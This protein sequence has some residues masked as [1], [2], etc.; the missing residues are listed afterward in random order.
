VHRATLKTGEQV[1]VKIQY[2]GIARTIDADMRNLAAVLFPARLGKDWKF[3]KANFEDIQRHLTAEVDYQREAEN[4]RRA[5]VLF[6]REDGIVVPQVY[7]LFSTNRVLT[8]E[9]LPGLHLDAFLNMK[10]SQAVRDDFGAKMFTAFYRLYYAFMNHADPHSGNYLFMHD[11]RL[12]LL[13]FGCV[14]HYN[15]E[16]RELVKWGEQLVAGNFSKMKE[17]L[18][19]VGVPERHFANPEFIKRQ[20]VF[21][22]WMIEPV[23]CHGPFDFGDGSRLQRG[24]EMFAEIVLKRENQAHPMYA[25]FFRSVF[26]HDALLYRLGAQ[27]DVRGIHDREVQA[28][29]R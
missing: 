23:S 28:L 19:Q 10:P 3:M 29:M 8:M 1:A 27:V 22:K 16:E 2:P 9:F 14:Q 7:D 12:G 5:K 21:T 20:E 26:G 17:V 11:G 18:R 13:D 4:L 25:Y 15:A 24:A 6:K